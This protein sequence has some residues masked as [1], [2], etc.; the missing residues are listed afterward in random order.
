MKYISSSSQ[1]TMGNQIG[2]QTGTNLVPLELLQ[3]VV[4]GVVDFHT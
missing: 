4:G 2:S 3:N 1:D